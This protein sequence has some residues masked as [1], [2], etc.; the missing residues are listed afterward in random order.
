MRIDVTP[1]PALYP[2]ESR[3]FGSSRGRLH[4]LDE[5][6][7]PP[8]MFFHGN[9]TWSFAYRQV[10]S[11]LRGRFRCIAVDY[12]GFGLSD[13]PAD[14]GYTIEEHVETVGEL[15]DHLGLTDLV[16]MG[17]DWGGPVGLAIATKRADRIRGVVLGNTWF[18]PADSLPMRLFSRTMSTGVMQRRILERNFFVERVMP[19]AM[20]TK[21][22]DAEF[23]HYRDVQPSPEARRGVA[24][25][26]K[27]IRTARPLLD[28]LARDVPER[29]GAKPALLVWGMKDPAFRPAFA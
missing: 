5:G 2:F 8:V 27:Q 18:W 14:Y 23:R 9:P 16:V 21:L 28:K 13:R 6:S 25:M 11:E 17:Q 24:E 7:G 26:P 4:Y 20:A 3:W 10:V 19:A 22:S 1:D 12:L 29:L 15:V